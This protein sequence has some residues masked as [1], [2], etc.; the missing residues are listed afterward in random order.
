MAKQKLS[1]AERFW[2]KVS[3]APHPKGCWVW[4]ANK[5]RRGY[6]HFSPQSRTTQ[7]AHRFS[8]VLAYGPIPDGLCVCHKCDNPACVNPDHLWAGTQKENMQD[9]AKK[10]RCM[11]QT[12]PERVASGD[13]NGTR[14]KPENYPRSEDRYNAKI[15]NA[16]ADEMRAEYASGLVT[17]QQIADKYGVCRSTAWKVIHFKR[18]RDAGAAC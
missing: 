9:C 12:H 17:L 5:V 8:Y 4:T 15:T 14:T 18:Y 2:S 6:G 10:G 13:R 11:A 16:G 3:K 1:V 7:K